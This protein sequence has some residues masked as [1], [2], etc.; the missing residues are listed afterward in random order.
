MSRDTIHNRRPKTVYFIRPVGMEGPVKVG[1][2][3][4][5][6]RRRG[7]LATWSPFPLEIIAEIAGDHWLERRFHAYF[8][9]T[10]Q[11][12]EWFGWSDRMAETVAAINAGTFD[13]DILPEPTVLGRLHFKRQP[14]T[15]DQK[16][17]A[18][19]SRRCDKTLERTGFRFG[20]WIQHVEHCD[21]WRDHIPA[22]EAYFA[23]P[24]VHGEPAGW[25]RA[26]EAR[27]KYLA[28]IPPESLAA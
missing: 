20:I 16:L 24:H 4:S 13:A 17:R 15:E 19:Y 9:D 3:G 14:W 2:S 8:R 12:R 28:S 10:Y 21:V 26:A 27:A 7:S 11:R 5:P 1:C 25:P 23:E 22:M 6:E 18:S